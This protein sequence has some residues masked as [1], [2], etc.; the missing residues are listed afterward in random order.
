MKR[1]KQIHTMR[2]R[3]KFRIRNHIRRTAHGVPRLSVFRSN[4]HIYAQIIDDVA[5]ETLVASTTLG[6]SDLTG[7]RVG[8]AAVGKEIAQKA[9]EKGIEKVVFD[10]GAYKY[11]GRIAALADAAREGGLKF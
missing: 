10:R 6:K 4:N 7:N 9:S 11:H 2:K 3:R 1:Q 5:G 8:A